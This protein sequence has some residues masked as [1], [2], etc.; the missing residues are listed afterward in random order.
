MTVA[1]DVDWGQASCLSVGTEAF[2]LERDPDQVRERV[3]GSCPIKKDCLKTALKNREQYGV[4]GGTLPSERLALIRR[5]SPNFKWPKT[6]VNA[7]YVIKKC[8]K[9]H[10]L[11][12]GNIYVDHRGYKTCAACRRDWAFDSYHRNE[13][14]A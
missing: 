10:E 1:D 13:M 9:G 7:E 4:W 2:Y 14:S 12:V 11:L 8:A 5:R 3:C 6:Q